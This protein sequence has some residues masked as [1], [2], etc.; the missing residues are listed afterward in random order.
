MKHRWRLLTIFGLV[1][2]CIWLARP[3]VPCLWEGYQKLAR[4]MSLNE[5]ETALGSQAASSEDYIVPSWG[6]GPSVPLTKKLWYG[7]DGTIV[8]R[9]LNDWVFSLNW[10][11]PET[12]LQKARRWLGV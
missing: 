10:Q 7:R 1:C 4:G 8:I 3:Q 9:F 5:V 2:S 6:S 11:E 12:L